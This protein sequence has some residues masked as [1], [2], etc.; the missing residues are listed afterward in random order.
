MVVAVFCVLNLDQKANDPPSVPYIYPNALRNAIDFLDDEHVKVAV[1]ETK[2]LIEQYEMAKVSALLSS[3]HV[4]KATNPS[5]F[6][7]AFYRNIATKMLEEVDKHNAASVIGTIEFTD[8]MAKLMKTTKMCSLNSMLSGNKKV[9][10]FGQS[11]SDGYTSREPTMSGGARYTTCGSGDDDRIKRYTVLV[12]RI[13]KMDQTALRAVYRKYPDG[14]AGSGKES[15]SFIMHHGLRQVFR[16]NLPREC[17]S[18]LFE[19]IFF[20]YVMGKALNILQKYP[21]PGE[22]WDDFNKLCLSST[23][24]VQATMD[25]VMKQL[26]IMVR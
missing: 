23:K 16:A 20:K 5:N 12:D 18:P 11:Y 21:E 25:A 6:K 7:T 13:N 14:G 1:L 26:R 2:R 3:Q 17:L 4:A 9:L 10:P 15:G 8:Q 19:R 24:A 22:S